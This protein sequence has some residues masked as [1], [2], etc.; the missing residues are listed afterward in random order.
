MRFCLS[1]LLT[2][3]MCCIG[4]GCQDP[5]PKSHMDVSPVES[6]STD[7]GTESL[8]PLDD[9]LKVNHLQALGTH[10][11]YHLASEITI[12]PWRYNHLPLDQQLG[13]QGIRQFEL[14]IYDE[15]GTLNVYHIERLDQNTNC[16]TLELCLSLMRSWS[17]DHQS[18]H[19]ILVLLEVKDSDRDVA[20]LLRAIESTAEV[21][22]GPE[23]ILRPED[24]QRGYSSLRAGL[25]AEGWPSLGESRG[26]VILVLHSG[27]EIRES[28]LNGD[29]VLKDRL[30]FPD[31]YGDL[32]ADYA[33]YHSINNPIQN[34]DLINDVVRAGHLVR[35]RADVNGEETVSLDTSRGEQALLSG[36][37]WIS[38]DYPQPAS[39][40]TYGFVI[41]L[42]TPSRCHP[43]MAPEQCE[44]S[45]IEA[46]LN[47]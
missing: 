12:L 35:T 45:A 9:L 41:P 42:G 4:L 14:D 25:E 46:L 34:F 2:L 39:D 20:E 18:H 8:Y 26:K 27:G 37:H 36:A 32:E 33:A 43:F 23:R 6:L 10:N 40:E 13:Q 38:T 7:Y 30:L 44:S 28:L 22:W 24:V 31:A 15:A 19:P 17:D 29:K 21:T 47:D 16:E 5:N 11:S 3:M 1:N